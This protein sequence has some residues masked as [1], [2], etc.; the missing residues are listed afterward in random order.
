[1]GKLKDL[2]NKKFGL[3]T[4]IEMTDKR[5]HGG[6]VIWK[7]KCECGAF[8]YIEGSR[9]KQHKSCG[10]LCKARSDDFGNR[11]SK[12]SESKSRLY[13]IW[14]NMK[15]RCYNNNDQRYYDYGG[16]GITVCDEWRNNY[17]NFANWAKEN[18]Y[19]DK[20]SIDRINNNGNYEPQNCKW[21]TNQE[22]AINKRSNKLLTYQGRTMTMKEWAKELN[23]PYGCL[24]TRLLR[25]WGV[26]RALTTPVQGR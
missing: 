4:V 2:T 9:L 3:L 25:G 19:N 7:C 16:R 21:S 10:C 5:G 18:G 14:N 24:Q 20:L 15:S 23:M 1:M 17:I 6:S 13:R 12:H 26:E 11:M 8:A 22:Q